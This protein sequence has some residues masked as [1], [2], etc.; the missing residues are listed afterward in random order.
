MAPPAEAHRG[1]PGAHPRLARTSVVAVAAGA[2]TVLPGF[3]VGV[4]ALQFRDDL[5]VS[6]GAVAGGRPAVRGGL[7]PAAPSRV[8]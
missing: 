8:R 2:G 5:D 1:R 3:L 7:L 6:V 4:L